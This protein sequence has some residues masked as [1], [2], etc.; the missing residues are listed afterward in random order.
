MISVDS[1]IIFSAFD[2]N[3]SNHH[4]AVALISKH[5]VIEGLVISPVVFAELSASSVRTQ[6]LQFLEDCKIEIFWDTPDTTWSR[7]GMAYGD[8]AKK[9]LG[10]VLPRRIFANFLIGAHAEHHN[11]KIMTFDTT[12]YTAVF[13]QLVLIS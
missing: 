5:A 9:R 11:L 13:P 3:D 4:R 1:N 8:Y 12:V 10:G 2:K 6:L 7:A